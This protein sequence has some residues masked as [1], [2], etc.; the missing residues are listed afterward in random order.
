MP[1]PHSLGSGAA[2]LAGEGSGLNVG[3]SHSESKDLSCGVR[4]FGSIPQMCFRP[5]PQGYRAG[6]LPGQSYP[7]FPGSLNLSRVC[8]MNDL[9]GKQST[10]RER[11]GLGP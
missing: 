6:W 1:R 11:A 2:A 10:E 7:I 3:P 9:S 8:E 5:R 4:M